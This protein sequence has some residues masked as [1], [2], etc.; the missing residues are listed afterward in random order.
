MRL[1][2]RPRYDT[3]QNEVRRRGRS[4]GR[5]IYLGLLCGLVLWIADMFVGDLLY[6][7]AE[8]LVMRNR[9]VLA[10]QYPAEVKSLNV[11]EGFSI[12]KGDV[13]VQVRSQKIEETL[14]QLYSDMVDGI[15]RA[16][17]LE[18]R[19]QVY[20]AIYPM[21]QRLYSEAREARLSSDT[22]RGE[23]LISNVRRADLLQSE[24]ESALE[25]TRIEVEQKTIEKNMPELRAA[26]SAS[27]EAIMRLREV[28]ADGILKA[29]SDGVVGYLHV[30][31]GS[32][33]QPGEP[34]M[35]LFTGDPFVLAYVPQGALYTLH[36]GDPIKI[37]VGLNTYYSRVS[38][39]YPVAGQL[40]QEFQNTFQ[41]VSRAQIVRLEFDPGQ[42]FPAL[43]AK[44]KLSA[45]GWPPAWLKR[46]FAS[47]YGRLAGK[48]P[49]PLTGKGDRL[50][51]S[52]AHS[53]G[54]DF[55]P[56]ARSHLVQQLQTGVQ[57]R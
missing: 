34:L 21:T 15:G 36:P 13:L 47:A 16:T 12:S 54:P 28:Y 11:E 10:T 41:P 4:W 45:V 50:D 40:P 42:D 19:N 26:V 32:V 53:A 22:L 57:S 3:L 55:G 37:S 51:A 39:I 17:D 35:E 2:R 56:I 9:V 29:P 20:E 38:R 8:G 23:G 7:R 31:Q 14:A 48:A 49:D 18:V 5:W 46:L 1:R 25:Q 6:F 52:H 44:T 27:R 33:I 30:A 24:M 43:F